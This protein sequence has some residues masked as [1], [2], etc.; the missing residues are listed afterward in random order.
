MV[1][2]NSC[3]TVL[4]CFTL[5]RT[6]FFTPIGETGLVL[7]EMYEA[8]GMIIRDA[9]DEEYVPLIEEQHLQK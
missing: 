9:P 4:L 1:Y 7:H 2:S 6:T 3:S 5:L 8:S